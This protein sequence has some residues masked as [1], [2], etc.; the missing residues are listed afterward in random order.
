MTLD[1]PGDRF[2]KDYPFLVHA[3]GRGLG[4]SRFSRALKRWLKANRSRFDGAIVHGLWRYVSFA[5]WRAFRGYKPYFV[6]VHGMLDPYFKRRFRLKYVL[7]WIYWLSSEYWVLRDARRVLF[8][9]QE[10][11]RRAMESFWLHRWNAQ[12]T[13]LGA[14]R[15][16]QDTET[17]RTAFFHRCPAVRG[18]RFLLFLGRINSKKGCDMLISSFMKVA[19]T[20]TELHLVMAGPDEQ[21][22]S[23]GFRAALSPAGFG[24]RVHWPGML[25]GDAKWGA[26]F[27]SEAFILP[28]HQEN[29]GVAVAESLACGR[30]V[31]LSDKVNIAHEIA[32]DGAGLMEPDTRAGT[33]HLLQRWLALSTD[34]RTA[35][36]EQALTTFQ[37]RFDMQKNAVAIWH[38]FNAVVSASARSEA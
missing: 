12:V 30:P 4:P 5:T 17:L 24:D 10:E 11:E 8:T 18:K 33:D 32:T 13:T 14:S 31:L 28:S 23:A 38:L 3:L 36:G 6:F 15:P 21:D 7:K 25:N 16:A 37:L 20:H 1:R 26:F 2:L 35:M 29:F 27:A 22:L 9:A 19:V 34:Q